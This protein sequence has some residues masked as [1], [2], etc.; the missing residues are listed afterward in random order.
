MSTD[1]STL[2]SRTALSRRELL[3][4]CAVGFGSLAATALFAEQSGAADASKAIGNAAAIRRAHFPPRAR[5]VIFLYMDG[6]PSQVDT[7][8]PKPLLQAEDGTPFKMKREPTQ[9]NNDGLTL[10]S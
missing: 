8:D 10:G 5:S 1:Y 4:K 7:F 2:L 6:G 3:E 9:F